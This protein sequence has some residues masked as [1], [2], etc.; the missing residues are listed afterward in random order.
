L[1]DHLTKI[2]GDIVNIEFG[3]LADAVKEGSVLSWVILNGSRCGTTIP[4]SPIRLHLLVLGK[5]TT[6]E[7]WNDKLH[8]KVD[9]LGG[10]CEVYDLLAEAVG[11]DAP[12][13]ARRVEV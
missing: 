13:G 5:A 9:D 11:V 2:G 8:A 10:D 7:V 4:R 6:L 12:A 3:F 1:H